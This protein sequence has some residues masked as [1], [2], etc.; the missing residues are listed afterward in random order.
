[1]I[2]FQKKMPTEFHGEIVQIPDIES[3]ILDYNREGTF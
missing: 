2:Q 3:R 1:M